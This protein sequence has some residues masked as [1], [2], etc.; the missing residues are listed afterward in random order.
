LRHDPD[1]REE[2]AVER[3]GLADDRRVAAEALAPETM[4]DHRDA[5]ARVGG[6]L[7]KARAEHRLHAE[8]QEEIRRGLDGVDALWIAAGL[9]QRQLRIPPRRGFVE[10]LRQAAI[11]DEVDRRN[12]LVRQPLAVVGL[13]H[14]C[15][16]I[17]I[18][19]RQRAQNH[20]VE[21]AENGRG[22]ADAQRERQ[23]RG[24]GEARRAAQQ[25][26]AEADVLK[27]CIHGVPSGRLDGSMAVMVDSYRR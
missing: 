26:P 22:R 8:H 2:R 3:D 25:A 16:A 6:T 14:R 1:D 9:G 12:P 18:G 13:P 7:G 19:I 27:Q 23:H 4:A 15:Q 24:D 20:A 11:V 5:L 10:H 17:G 21:D